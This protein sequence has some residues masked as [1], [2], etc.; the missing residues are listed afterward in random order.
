MALQLGGATGNVIDHGAGSS[1]ASINVGTIAF[2]VKP[3]DITNNIRNLV[4]KNSG[5]PVGWEMFRRGANGATLRFT[6]YNPGAVLDIISNAVLSAGVWGY[7]V[8]TWDAPGATGNIY[9]GS[10]TAAAAAQT[11]SVT[12]AGTTFTETAANLN[13]GNSSGLSS[14]FPGVFAW[15]SLWSGVNLTLAQINEQRLRLDAPVAK[16]NNV[17]FVNYGM[18]GIGGVGTQAD[19]S[20]SNNHGTITGATLAAHPPLPIFRYNIWSPYTVASGPI[21]GST[22][23]GHST[24]VVET[25]IRT[26]AG[27]WTGTASI[28][29]AADAERLAFNAGEYME[30]EVVE[31]GTSTVELLQNNYQAGDTVLLRYRD[32]ATEAACLAA[33]W[34]NYTVPFD[35][36]GFVQVRLESTL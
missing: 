10:L 18:H 11:A 21:V 32:G 2:W 23:W 34:T 31:T 6:V 9:Y 35:S 1:L 16:A 8:A 29:N 5:T 26:F 20:G 12:G 4:G 25:N 17:L 30:S 15:A 14:S 28:E 13:I 33:S 7:I 36:A 27:N 24:G 22:T 3:D 19:W